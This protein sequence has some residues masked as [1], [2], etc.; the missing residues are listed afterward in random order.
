VG[1]LL[2]SPSPQTDSVEVIYLGIAA[3]SRGRGLGRALLAHGLGLVTDR[4]ERMMALAVDAR[5]T[6]A[7]ALYARTGFRTLRRREAFVAH[8]DA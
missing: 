1:A 7:T 2:L 3:E 4:P 5:N 8:L 6:P